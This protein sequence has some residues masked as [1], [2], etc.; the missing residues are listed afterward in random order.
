MGAVDQLLQRQFP[1]YLDQF[2]AKDTFHGD[3]NWLHVHYL[4]TVKPDRVESV[5]SGYDLSTINRV[6]MAKLAQTG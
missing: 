5:K 1:L 3:H 6:Y 4:S 2:T